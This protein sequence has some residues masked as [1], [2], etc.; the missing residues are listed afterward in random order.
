MAST[1][2]LRAYKL[3]VELGQSGLTC[4]V[5]HEH[6]ID[7]VVAVEQESNSYIMKNEDL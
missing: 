6:S 2:C 4:V 5:E 3:G 1:E 7:H